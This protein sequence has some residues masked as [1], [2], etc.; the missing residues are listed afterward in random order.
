LP[1]ST[2]SPASRPRTETVKKSTF[3]FFVIPTMAAYIDG[4]TT[5]YSYSVDGLKGPSLATAI[6]SMEKEV[7]KK[8]SALAAACKRSE[9]KFVDPDF[10]PSDSDEFGSRSLYGTPPIAPK[11]AYPKP[12]KV[13]WDRPRYADGEEGEDE[14]ESEE[15]NNDNDDEDDEFD[16][17]DDEYGDDNDKSDTWCTKGR[18]FCGGSGSG[19]IVQGSLGDCWFLGAL[20]VLATR[21][22][23]VENMFFNLSKHK[24]VGIFVC[25]FFKDN[26]HHFVVIDD[27]IPCYDNRDGSPVFAKCRDNNELWVPLVEKAYAK[28]HGS[29]KALIG[30]YVHYGL[31]DMTGFSPIQMVIKE[32]HQGFHESW[33]PEDLWERL[34]M[35]K[36]WG[37]LMGCSIQQRP[38]EKKKSHEAE[39]NQGL[40]LMHAYGFIDLNEITLKDGTKQRLCR[41][42]NPWGFGEWEGRWGDE[43]EERRDNDEQISKV[44]SVSEA[45]KTEMNKMDGTFF[46]SFEDWLDNFTHIFVAVDFPEEW[47]KAR[48]SGAWDADLGGNRTV[49]TFSSN[50]K[51]RLKLEEDAAVFIGLSSPDSRLTHGVDYWRTPLQQMPMS[52]DVLRCGEGDDAG[53]LAKNAKDRE[54]IVGS[55]DPDG[56][57]T[58]QPPYYYQAVQIQT[59]LSKGDYLIIP[60][61]YKRKIGGDLFMSVTSSSPFSLE[62]KVTIDSE[63][64]IVDKP[65]LPSGITQQQFSI[66]IEDVREKLFSQADKLGISFNQISAEFKKPPNTK[67]DKKLFKQKLI[68]LGFNLTDFP[69][70]DF[71]AIDVDGSGEVSAKE[72]NDFFALAVANSQLPSPPPDPP[73]DDLQNQPTDLEGRLSVSCLEAKGLI[74]SIAWFDSLGGGRHDGKSVQTRNKTLVYEPLD[75]YRHK[76]R[77]TKIYREDEEI[78]SSDDKSDRSNS[79]GTGNNDNTNKI[80]DNVSSNID[81]GDNSA[82]RARTASAASRL[83]SKSAKYN[84]RTGRG[85]EISTIVTTMQRTSDLIAKRA[86]EK[87]DLE[88]DA[89]VTGKMLHSTEGLRGLE[90]KR[91]E[92]LRNVKKM[93]R[94]CS[95]DTQPECWDRLPKGIKIEESYF[96]YKPPPRSLGSG[97]VSGVTGGRGEGDGG[98]LRG[99]MRKWIK[100]ELVHELLGEM[101]DNVFDIRE[102]RCGVMKSLVKLDTA[103][104]AKKEKRNREIKKEIGEGILVYQRFEPINV[105]DM[106]MLVGQ[107]NDSGSFMNTA[108]TWFRFLDKDGSGMI[109]FKD[110]A[111]SLEEMSVFVSNEDLHLLI[112]RFQMKDDDKMISYKEFLKGADGTEKGKL[113]RRE[114]LG[115]VLTMEEILLN[116]KRVLLSNGKRLTSLKQDNDSIGITMLFLDD[117]GCRLSSNDIYRLARCFGEDVGALMDYVDRTSDEDED[118]KIMLATLRKTLRDL[119]RRRCDLQK[120]DDRESGEFGAEGESDVNA[121]FEGVNTTKAIVVLNSNK[122]WAQLAPSNATEIEFERVRTKLV[123]MLT[124]DAAFSELFQE[125]GSHP[126][127]NNL[128]L[129]TAVSF[130]LDE[131]LLVSS[132]KETATHFTFADI[133]SFIRE[134]EINKLE[135][136]FYLALCVLQDKMSGSVY[137]LVDVYVDK[138]KSSLLVTVR[139]PVTSEVHSMKYEEDLSDLL[140]SIPAGDP[141]TRVIAATNRRRMTYSSANF[142]ETQADDEKYNLKNPSNGGIL[143]PFNCM[144]NPVGDGAIGRFTSRLNLLNVGN[145]GSMLTTSEQKKFVDHLR[146]LFQCASLPFFVTVNE[147]CLSFAIDLQTTRK[148]GSIYK[149]IFLNLKKDKKL[150]AFLCNTFSLLKV[151]LST[152]D[153]DTNIVLSWSEF[154]AHLNGFRN[155]FCTLELLPKRIEPVEGGVMQ[156]TA[157]A[158]NFRSGVADLEGGSHPK[159]HKCDFD[160]KFLPPAIAR[161]PILFTDVCKMMISE[162][163]VEPQAKLFIIMVRK[164][165]D[166]SLICTAYDPKSSSDFLVDFVFGASDEGR[167]DLPLKWNVAGAVDAI[168]V[169]VAQKQLEVGVKEGKLKL[170]YCITPRILCK[171]YNKVGAGDEFL[172]QAELSISGVLSNCGQAQSEWITLIRDNKL[173][174][175]VLIN[176]RFKRQIDIMM[177]QKSKE[178]KRIKAKE[179][180]SAKEMQKSI[181]IGLSTSSLLSLSSSTTPGGDGKDLAAVKNVLEKNVKQLAQAMKEGA[182]KEKLLEEARKEARNLTLAVNKCKNEE[183][184]LEERLEEAQKKASESYAL[185]VEEKMKDGRDRGQDSVIG[186]GGEVEGLKITLKEEIAKRSILTEEL[187]ETKRLYELATKE[188]QMNSSKGGDVEE[189]VTSGKLT[190]TG[191]SVLT[192]IKSDLL[193]RCPDDPTKGIANMLRVMAGKEGRVEIG[194]LR[195]VMGLLGLLKLPVSLVGGQSVEDVW[196]IFSETF[197]DSID[198]KSVEEVVE[199]FR[200]EWKAEPKL[201]SKQEPD[202]VTSETVG[203]ERGDRITSPRRPPPPP[204]SNGK[205]EPPEPPEPPLPEGWEMRTRAKDGKVYYVNHNT[206]KTQWKRPKV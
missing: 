139:N 128:P 148:F 116:V 104:H 124:E 162:G 78:I 136:K 82:T 80:H 183:R 132:K 114:L 83:L 48:A 167:G 6:T 64:E 59:T 161:M 50:P 152:Y 60:S 44:F 96:S 186:S 198:S 103:E 93:E 130:I 65:G 95:S 67:I 110:F 52:F 20:S 122:M 98:K 10:G 27:R 119:L 135:K 140:P 182:E 185:L 75:K 184:L 115:E 74:P 143:C 45:E 172:G 126:H 81:D 149:A 43:S 106:D 205:Q 57:L 164:G 171:I 63:T 56:T 121:S 40:R 38:G 102:F 36:S 86:A 99:V 156:N 66:H 190:L 17:F 62:S 23:L 160:F 206:R 35:W 196:E 157:D 7:E 188:L 117:L 195:E 39:G 29:Y 202:S 142:S 138:D 179:I 34:S 175:T 73:E 127:T 42:R 1:L 26:A 200:Q 147:L 118:G 92:F 2:S 168:D 134:D 155:P 174:G 61:L 9:S 14:S 111:E 13:R 163:L 192:A 41:C 170:G 178:A 177:E 91:L 180:K 72:F 32:G 70:E 46:M 101:V 21:Q 54:M 165:S 123:Q 191:S 84:E 166:G 105:V 5:V 141:W 19:D 15:E 154:L 203:G 25:R 201:E 53:E 49:K 16:E 100:E 125:D 108:Q 197:R 109:S 112:Q 24:D 133:D 187:G 55:K 58:K 145:D 158:S 31:G 159:F 150:H 131:A 144:Q 12:D 181:G 199:L 120:N 22:E 151:T 169:E 146:T 94:K 3:F 113:T 153:G 137:H 71:L 18:L 89:E 79:F 47:D 173:A 4:M 51:F 176:M 107:K 37:S 204:V 30:G 193:D 189:V 88:K 76:R 90:K 97:R 87:K 28:I 77:A 33:E 11:G 8:V 69:D 129:S 85:T 68:N 194:I